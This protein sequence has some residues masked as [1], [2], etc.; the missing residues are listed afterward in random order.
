MMRLPVVITPYEDELLYSYLLRLAKTA[1]YSSYKDFYKQYVRPNNQNRVTT[2]NYLR[3]DSNLDL[4]YVFSQLAPLLDEKEAISDFYMS[5]SYYSVVAP[6]LTRYQQADW[7]NAACRKDSGKSAL[8]AKINADKLK[9]L[10]ICPDCLRNHGIHFKRIHQIPGLKVCPI[11]GTVLQ[12]YA[13]THGE[14]LIESIF[15]PITA[16]PITDADVEYARFVKPLLSGMLETNVTELAAGVKLYLVENGYDLKHSEFIYKRAKELGRYDYCSKNTVDFMQGLFKKAGQFSR[17][18]EAEQMLLTLFLLFRNIED[19]LQYVNEE[20]PSQQ[21]FEKHASARGYT[22][23][24]TY[25]RHAITMRHELCRYEFVTSPE[26]F[27]SGWECPDCDS[28]LDD[29]ELFAKIFSRTYGEDYSLGSEFI[30]LKKPMLVTHKICGKKYS[31]KASS[32]LN[33]RI[34]CNCSRRNE[35]L[36]KANYYMHKYPDW[37]L[38]KFDAIGAPVAMLH[39]PCGHTR[40]FYSF[41]GFMR[42]PSCKICESE[43][44]IRIDY[45]QRLQEILGNRIIMLDSFINADTELCFHCVVCGN[46]FKSTPRNMIERCFCPKCSSRISLSYESLR[47][48][49]STFSGGRYIITNKNNNTGKYTVKDIQSGFSKSMNRNQILLEAITSVS[50]H[51]PVENKQAVLEKS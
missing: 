15:T 41:D 33:E 11:H 42:S 24:S 35:S 37:K 5:H 49:V 31:V 21:E 36:I 22:L 18:M 34:T 25:H 26:A 43:K 27:M 39:I 10:K 45:L 1:G 51:L 9:T 19:V 46:T 14:E 7:I 23:V 32:L 2:L 3:Y 29:N 50:Y 8:T 44:Y 47:D 16:E 38:I 17:R 12:E 30:S 40:T 4:S 28:S 20:Y 48:V 13:G 6:L